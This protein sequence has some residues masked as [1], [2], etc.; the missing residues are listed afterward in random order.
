MSRR[1]DSQDDGPLEGGRD[2]AGDSN[3]RLDDP[4]VIS[5]FS[6]ADFDPSTP[7]LRL[8]GGSLGGKAQGLA[9]MA[10]L[11]GRS[12]LADRFP[13]VQIAVPQS[14][15]I[16]TDVFLGFIETNDLWDFVHGCDD[17]E[18]IAQACL[19]ARLD[20]GLLDDLRA[21]LSVVEH[22]LAVRSSSRLE[23]SLRLPFAGLYS[24]YMIP[25]NHP[26]IE[27]RLRQLAD[28][29][30]LVYASTFYQAPKSLLGSTP[31]QL[32][33]ERMGVVVQRLA[34]YRYED[35][36]YPNFSGVAQ[37]H[38]YY[39]LGRM[40]AEDGLV[41][42]ALGLG[43]MVVEGGDVL[44][45][46]PARPTVP[47]GFSSSEEILRNSQRSFFALDLSD[48]AVE[49]VPRSDGPLVKLGLADAE[50]HGTL[51]P[52]GSV[53][54]REDG[55]C[56]DGIHATGP[57]L[58]T[59]THV[60]RS[61]LFPLAP[62]IAELL[63]SG[64]KS[65]GCEVEI[66]FACNL[67]MQSS[68]ESREFAV[69]QC[70]P[71]LAGSDEV[72]VTFDGMDEERVLCS[73]S[74]SLGHGRIEDIRDVV[75]VS[76]DRWDFADTAGI[77]RQVGL[78][79]A[80]LQDEGRRCL[81][82]GLGRWGTSDPVQ[83]IPVE[84]NDISAA[85]VIVEVGWHGFTVV[86]SQGS[87]FF[88]NITSLRVGYLTVNP[89]SEDDRIEWAA[90]DSAQTMADMQHVRHVR[91]DRPVEVRMDGRSGRAVVLLPGRPGAGRRE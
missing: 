33:E 80:S 26:D 3:D 1:S 8:G 61:G 48:P 50:K 24:T 5:E 6:R 83:G 71:M 28:A 74:K 35:V 76:P 86:P 44:R 66:E 89:A 87:H 36:Y 43:K 30:K 63:S 90:L 91:F 16:G 84:W 60:L 27:V 39:P 19:D 70:R 51:A 37:S 49:I 23:D 82:I 52:V 45:F 67:S 46:S 9:S 2:C 69:L 85:A 65:L 47:P 55:V 4:G 32:E 58:V 18:R 17:D 13:D 81:L 34:A 12:N 21:Y 68:T 64:R 11:L 20:G 62:I 56:R 73:S 42:V 10:S 79:N 38:N 75:F 41:H 54:V 78:V 57:R 15:A 88:H 29:I 22:P 59:F 77:A 40:K 25:N 14:L 31:G 72:S 53:Y 7:F